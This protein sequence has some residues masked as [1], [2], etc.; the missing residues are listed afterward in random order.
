MVNVA[1]TD[2]DNQR[3]MTPLG[4]ER[5]RSMGILMAGNGLRPGRIATSERCRAGATADMLREGFALI[6]PEAD[7][8]PAER[9]AAANPAGQDP[10]GD[11]AAL[12]E[13]LM[14]WD[15][16]GEGDADGPLLVVSHFDAIEALTR[17]RVYEGEILI[18]DPDRGGRVLGY[19][20]LR[21]AAPDAG[22]FGGPASD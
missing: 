13:R 19:I 9:L 7:P 21:S 10:A 4:E 8:V 6:D 22:R 3:I 17:F 12:R 1:P 14:A 16:P 5:M 11:V 2:C 20:R 18:F 15:G